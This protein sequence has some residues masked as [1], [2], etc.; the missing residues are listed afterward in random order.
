MNQPR[1]SLRTPRHY[2][3]QAMSEAKKN[4]NG[5]DSTGIAR[6]VNEIKTSLRLH[7]YNSTE[8][9]RNV[10]VEFPSTFLPY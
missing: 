7:S 10:E 9:K 6:Q 4:A 2:T 1:K 3:Y 5:R 8:S